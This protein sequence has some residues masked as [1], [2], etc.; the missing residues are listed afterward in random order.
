MRI[1]RVGVLAR[2]IERS[3]CS[4]RAP[5]ASPDG[6]VDSPGAPLAPG[7]EVALEPPQA[8]AMIANAPTRASKRFC[9]M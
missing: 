4:K 8:D 3:T 2:Q 5:D 9:D 7:D 1:D 6:A